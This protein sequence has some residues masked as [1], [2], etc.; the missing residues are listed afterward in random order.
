[1]FARRF[2][3]RSFRRRG[4]FGLSRYVTDSIALSQKLKEDEA[5]SNTS[6][7]CVVAG[8]TMAGVRKVRKVRNF[9]L[10]I[11]CPLN[12]AFALVYFPEGIAPKSAKLNESLPDSPSSLYTPEQHVMCSGICRDNTLTISRAFG[13]RSLSNN[14]TIFLLV[15][16]FTSPGDTTFV[17]ARITF[18]IAFG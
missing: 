16:P 9:R 2:R 14:D 10:E 18:A 6:A 5:T 7:F 17:T 1:M 4:T 8:I 12:I 3:R 11:S 15:R 13:S